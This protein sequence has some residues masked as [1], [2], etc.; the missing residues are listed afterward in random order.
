MAADDGRAERRARVDQ[1]LV[2]KRY[3][4]A[5]SWRLR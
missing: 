3:A 2:D 5:Q 4:E 1:L